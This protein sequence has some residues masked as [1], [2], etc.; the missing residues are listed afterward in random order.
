MTR[1]GKGF[2]PMPA[3]GQ[4]QR[5]SEADPAIVPV[6]S[7]PSSAKVAFLA[8]CNRIAKFSLLSARSLSAQVCT[9]MVCEVWLGGKLIRPRTA[10]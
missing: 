6:A 8:L 7:A 4:R 5:R 3:A 10:R 2:V 9:E 1:S